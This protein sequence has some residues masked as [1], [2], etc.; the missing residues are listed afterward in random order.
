MS[1]STLVLVAA[2]ALMW[3]ALMALRPVR[4]FLGRHRILVAVLILPLQP[5]AL[6]GLG[7]AVWLALTEFQSIDWAEAAMYVA[8]F[9]L[10]YLN[11]LAAFALVTSLQERLN[12]RRDG[13]PFLPGAKQ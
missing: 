13:A 9:A 8:M 4:S 12:R 1:L 11:G 5:F 7:A 2:V 3:F 10:A 6:I